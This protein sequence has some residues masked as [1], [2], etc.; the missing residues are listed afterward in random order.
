[1]DFCPAQE[2]QLEQ[3]ESNAEEG[4]HAA[5]V[6]RHPIHRRSLPFERLSRLPWWQGDIHGSS[7][8]IDSTGEVGCRVGPGAGQATRTPG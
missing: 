5:I 4:Q 7:L 8:I 3:A 2:D 6:A 1:M